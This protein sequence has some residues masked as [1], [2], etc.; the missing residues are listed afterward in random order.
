MAEDLEVSLNI[1]V[2]HGY[3]REIG[4][5]NEL[6]WKLPKDMKRFKD[7]TT[8]HVVVMGRKTAESIGRQLPNRWNIILT[9]E[10]RTNQIDFTGKALITDDIETIRQLGKE[11]EVFIIGGEQ[12][13]K[14]FLPY[15]DR[16][17]ITYVNG[18]FPHADTKFP[19][20]NSVLENCL[21]TEYEVIRSDEKNPYDM[22]FMTYEK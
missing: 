3:N 9:K 17:Y 19:K 15:A 12:I 16:F 13:Y 6:L 7:L 22:I 4:Y 18:S 14:E 11:R 10:V 20:Y 1:I 8:G 2:A 21:C 5:Q